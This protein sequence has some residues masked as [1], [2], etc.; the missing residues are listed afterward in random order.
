VIEQHKLID[1]YVK[2][3]ISEEDKTTF[4]L[5][6]ANDKDLRQEVNFR[7]AIVNNFKFEQVK[8]T[9]EQA[10]LENEQEA[11]TQTKLESVTATIKQAQFE[12]TISRQKRIRLYRNLSIAATFLVMIGGGWFWSINQSNNLLTNIIVSESELQEVTTVNVEKIKNLVEKANQAIKEK[13]F[14]LVLSTIDQLRKE[15]GFET[16]EILQNESYIYFK[17]KNYAK[18]DRQIDRINDAQTQNKVRWQ[19]STLYLDVDET[20]LA[21]QQL[22]KIQEGSYKKKAIKRLKKLN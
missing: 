1:D 7:K 9:I 3:L 15:E 11:A 18:A 2:G 16:D 5:E 10:K 8:Q 12:N 22:Q 17:Q 19:L 4:E 6:L 14:E 20:D 21:K 13:D